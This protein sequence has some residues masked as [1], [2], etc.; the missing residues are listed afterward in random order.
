MA[1]IFSQ[2][3][4]PQRPVS[5]HAAQQVVA[6]QTAPP[7]DLRQA[8]RLLSYR[9]RWLM[10][11][12][13]ER[14]RW[15]GLLALSL[16]LPSLPGVVLLIMPARHS[17]IGLQEQAQK[18]IGTGLPEVPLTQLSAQQKLHNFM[19]QFPPAS[20]RSRIVKQ[21]MDIADSQA[22]ALEEVS[23]RM[24]A[25]LPLALSHYRV[26]FSTV[27]TYAEIQQFLNTVL[28]DMPLLTLEALTLTRDSAND[29]VIEARMQF[30]LHFAPS[31]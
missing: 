28:N 27:A 5:E 17:L 24:D 22:I 31:P 11:R 1:S 23:Y 26:D 7:A 4:L 2:R 18:P 16:V 20:T 14:L 6:Q 29:A 8:G 19:Q 15:Q 30:V 3:P 25:K 13:A 9:L 10:Q 21:L 12:Y